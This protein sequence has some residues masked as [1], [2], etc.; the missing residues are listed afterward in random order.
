M[1]IVFNPFV[2]SALFLHEKTGAYSFPAG[3]FK[4]S[5]PR[6]DAVY[7]FAAALSFS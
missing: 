3:L 2:W 5:A 7:R 4:V 1:L 6:Q